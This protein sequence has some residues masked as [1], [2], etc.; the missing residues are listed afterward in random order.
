MAEITLKMINESLQS[1]FTREVEFAMRV[2]SFD[3]VVDDLYDQVFRE[4]SL[5]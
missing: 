2:V 4:L 1:F 3:G 5:S